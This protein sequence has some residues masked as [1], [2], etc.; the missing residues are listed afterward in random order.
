ML[1][2][3]DAANPPGVQ[4]LVTGWKINVTV[5]SQSKKMNFKYFLNHQV[6]CLQDKSV[7]NDLMKV[8]ATVVTNMACNDFLL[9][10][11]ICTDYPR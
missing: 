7:P 8:N 5:R 1:P 3:L 4:G 2:Q 6:V 10:E 9:G 11:T